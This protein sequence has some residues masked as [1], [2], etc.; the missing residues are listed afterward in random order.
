MPELR[1]PFSRDPF[2]ARAVK[3]RAPN[4]VRDMK[5]CIQ[6]GSSDLMPAEDPREFRAGDAVTTFQFHDCTDCGRKQ[7]IR[8][9]RRDIEQTEG[10]TSPNDIEPNTPAP[11]ETHSNATETDPG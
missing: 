2:S 11:P 3:H 1:V 6:C 8:T 7:L 5:T 10:E 9:V 4:N